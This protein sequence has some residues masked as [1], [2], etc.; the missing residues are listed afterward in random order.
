MN[1]RIHILSAS[2]VALFLIK[3]FFLDEPILILTIF[4]IL[5]IFGGILPDIDIGKSKLGKKIRPLSNILQ[6][7]FGHRGA[8]HS[9]LFAFLA[10]LLFLSIGFEAFGIGLTAGILV[11]MGVDVLETKTKVLKLRIISII[12]EIILVS[13]H[14]LFL[15]FIGFN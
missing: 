11:H 13:L 5:A 2:L 1:Y 10:Y 7:I 6:I 9:I 4:Y 8:V 12:T 3:L 14:G 15:I